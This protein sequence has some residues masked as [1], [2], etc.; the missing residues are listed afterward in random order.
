MVA[1]DTS[2]MTTWMKVKCAPGHFEIDLRQQPERSGN[3]APDHHRQVLQHDGHADGGNQRR[4]ARRIAQ[5]T[6][7]D[8]L[9][10]Q[11]S[12]MQTSTEALLPARPARRPACRP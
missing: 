5:R 1:A 11:P 2:T 6:V 10:P 12:A 8:A 4:Q 3:C 9:Q 7:G